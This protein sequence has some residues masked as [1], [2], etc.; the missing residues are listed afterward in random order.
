MASTLAA[1]LS[2]IASNS[3]NS[4]DLKA[5]KARHSKSLIFEPR[6]A[7]SQNF[8]TIYSISHEGFQEL[9]LLDGRF[10]EFQRDIFAEQS[11]ELDRSQMTITQNAELDTR[12]E[13]FLYLI[14]GRLRL[15]PAIKA[16]EWLVRK[17]RSV[18]TG[19]YLN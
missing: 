1:Q 5:L 12:L 9:C 18:K 19:K 2:V 14:S 6:A 13:A 17:F 8:E 3:R 15:S 7:A 11:Q 10:L 4:L 16:I